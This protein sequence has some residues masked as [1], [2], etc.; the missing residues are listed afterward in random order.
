[1]SAKGTISTHLFQIDLVPFGRFV[2]GMVASIKVTAEIYKRFSEALISSAQ[3]IS[4]NVQYCE[5]SK[6]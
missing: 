3:D 2:H 6:F 4:R 1:M 5:E